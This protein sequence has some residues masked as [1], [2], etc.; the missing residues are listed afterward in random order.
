[1]AFYYCQAQVLAKNGAIKVGMH[2]TVKA[3]HECAILNLSL[4]DRGV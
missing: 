2:D 1:M 4:R 3:A